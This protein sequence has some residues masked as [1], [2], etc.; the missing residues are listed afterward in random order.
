MHAI[1]GCPT[2][3]LHRKKHK[4]NKE[5]KHDEDIEQKHA[6]EYFVQKID[7]FSKKG[8]LLTCGSKHSI[9][10]EDEERLG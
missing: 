4:D 1:T 9:S 7:E 8:Y 10:E 2:R 3:L 6:D 5:D